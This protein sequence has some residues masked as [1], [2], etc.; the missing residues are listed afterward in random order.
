[1]PFTREDHGS[2]A[3]LTLDHGD[4]NLFD[5]FV[6]DSFASEVAALAQDPPRGVLIRA[7]GRVVSGGVD[8]HE[9]EPLTPETGS[10]LWGALLAVV[11]QL[12]DLPCPT[13]FAAHG[14]CPHG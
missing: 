9:F 8:V 11:H 7:R 6:F 3:V 13:V 1:M 5:R 10:A 14:L 4:L 2:L 12:E